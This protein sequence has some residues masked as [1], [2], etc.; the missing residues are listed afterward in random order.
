MVSDDQIVAIAAENSFIDNVWFVY[1]ID[2]KYVNHS[3]NNIGDYGH[4]V[5]KSQLYFL[6][7]YLEKLNDNK[8]GVVYQRSKKTFSFNQ[9]LLYPFIELERNYNKKEDLFFLSNNRFIEVQ[10]VFNL[11]QWLHY[12]SHNCFS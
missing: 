12:F 9:K 8:K 6:C 1:V 2:V 5:P 3:S 11:Q 4:N 10:Y 7:N